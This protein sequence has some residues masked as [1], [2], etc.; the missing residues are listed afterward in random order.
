MPVSRLVTVTAA[1]GINA[2]LESVT[3]PKIDPS[4]PVCAEVPIE[5]SSRNVTAAACL[6]IMV[7]H[8]GSGVYAQVNARHQHCQGSCLAL[9]LLS[10]AAGCGTAGVIPRRRIRNNHRCLP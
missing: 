7:S 1:L 9:R 5:K 10:C 2:P 4:V 8:P 6:L 3:V